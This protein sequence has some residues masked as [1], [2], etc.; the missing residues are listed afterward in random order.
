M[1]DIENQFLILER[2]ELY[3][4]LP[5]INAT[6]HAPRPI[7]RFIHIGSDDVLNS[8]NPKMNNPKIAKIPNSKPR[9]RFTA[10]F[11]H[12]IDRILGL[13]EFTLSSIKERSSLRLSNL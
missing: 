9:P 10:S 12:S 11:M 6:T 2:I 1:K 5:M 8:D 4:T 3:I 13:K 7:A